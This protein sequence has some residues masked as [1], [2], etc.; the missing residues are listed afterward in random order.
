LRARHLPLRTAPRLSHAL[1]CA[2]LEQVGLF[3]HWKPLAAWK[4][5][6]RRRVSKKFSLFII[7]Q[8]CK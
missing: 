8:S 5:G 4:T 6:R 2:P 7:V 1:D 3:Q